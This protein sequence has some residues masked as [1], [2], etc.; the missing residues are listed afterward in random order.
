M[1]AD[2]KGGDE[3]GASGR[4]GGDGGGDGG[5]GTT[6]T[7]AGMVALQPQIA[8]NATQ[9]IA[10]PAWMRCVPSPATAQQPCPGVID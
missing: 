6:A 5:N 8:S 3:D 1:G 7:M 10:F 9:L 4:G 2:E